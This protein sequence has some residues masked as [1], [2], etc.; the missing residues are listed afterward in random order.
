MGKTANRTLSISL[1]LLI[2]H[3]RVGSI[4]H[5]ADRSVTDKSS[6]SMPEISGQ[7]QEIILS[8]KDCAVLSQDLIALAKWTQL[9]DQRTCH[10]PKVKE[11]ANGCV[12]HLG[13]CVPQHVQKFHG[14]HPDFDGPNSWNLALVLA[15]LL[16]ALRFT[17]PGEFAFYI[18]SPLCRK[19]ETD[20]PPQTGDIGTY[21]TQIENPEG[22]EAE[23]A[24]FIFV[25]PRLSYAKLGNKKQQP[26][27]LIQ[28]EIL[29]ANFK[30]LPEQMCQRLGANANLPECKGKT[31]FYRCTTLDLFMHENEERLSKTTK[32]LA[33]KI[34]QHECETSAR[35]FHNE[36]SLTL[37]E[38]KNLY[39]VTVALAKQLDLKTAA[40]AKS[41]KE[42]FFIGTLAL[43]LFSMVSALSELTNGVYSKIIAVPT[44][45]DYL[46]ESN[47]E[48][49]NRRTKN[50]KKLYGNFGRG[51]LP[52]DFTE[53]L[54]KAE[55]E[56]Q[57]R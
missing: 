11:D 25:S 1:A 28:T 9:A 39:A 14:K 46:Y 20:A 10:A 35:Y 13:D 18:N 31:N 53:E 41:E 42:I 19:L 43:R 32:A 37:T 17:T 50:I 23:L 27:Q 4:A 22:G 2:T 8:H 26:Y 3:S 47:P 16:P 15:K 52:F 48:N 21:R 24:A 44:Q 56:L 33:E 34:V 29:D 55:Q 40:Q 6:N 54:Q 49:A 57:E 30:N 12:A 51:S 7:G 45:E 38:S 36:T 5:S